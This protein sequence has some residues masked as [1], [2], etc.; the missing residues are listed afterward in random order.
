MGNALN[1]HDS[2][3]SVN[4]SGHI[5]ARRRSRR[6]LTLGADAWVEV[7]ARVSAAVAGLPDLEVAA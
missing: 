7:V 5:P 4:N 1:L 6:T 2:G 3:R